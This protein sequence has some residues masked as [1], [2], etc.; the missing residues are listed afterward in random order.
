MCLFFQAN[1]HTNGSQSFPEVLVKGQVRNSRKKGSEF[2]T[3]H[4]TC[5][6]CVQVT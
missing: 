3:T 5:E 6:A 4:A 1:G 2:S